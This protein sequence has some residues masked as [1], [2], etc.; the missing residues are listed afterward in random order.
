MHEAACF[1]PE[2]ARHR[3]TGLRWNRS[4]RA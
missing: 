2:S 1:Y 3:R 4:P